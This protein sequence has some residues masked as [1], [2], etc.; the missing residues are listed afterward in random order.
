MFPR[1]FSIT[2]CMTVAAL[3]APVLLTV[4]SEASQRDKAFFK[5]GSGTGQ[6]QGESKMAFFEH[7][8]GA[9]TRYVSIGAQKNTICRP[10]SRS[11][12]TVSQLRHQSLF[13]SAT[14]IPA[15][16]ASCS[17]S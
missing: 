1:L 13:S 2:R 8:S 5:P 10:P 6:R 16:S 3:V 17:Q 4:P 11:F 14:S 15:T 9:Y 7:R 12:K